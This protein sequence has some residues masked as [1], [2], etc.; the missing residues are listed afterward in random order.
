MRADPYSRATCNRFRSCATVSRGRTHPFRVLSAPPHQHQ[1][2]RRLLRLPDRLPRLGTIR[3]AVSRE[4]DRGGQ[5]CSRT[6]VLLRTRHRCR[7]CN[8]SRWTHRWI[9]YRLGVGAQSPA[10]QAATAGAKSSAALRARAHSTASQRDRNSQ[11]ARIAAGEPASSATTPARIPRCQRSSV[12][13]AKAPYVSEVSRQERRAGLR[14]GRTQRER[15]SID[16][17]RTQPLSLSRSR[18]A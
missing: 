5:F 13:A 7:A 16:F 10:P 6:L 11:R 14:R 1:G 15:E 2:S 4:G 18:L 3:V 9:H 17:R 12:T 8:R